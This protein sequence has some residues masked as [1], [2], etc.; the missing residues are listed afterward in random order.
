MSIYDHL[1]HANQLDNIIVVFS[2]RSGQAKNLDTITNCLG[3]KLAS[4][5][6]YADESTSCSAA[7]SDADGVYIEEFDI[8]VLK[9]NNEQSSQITSLTN[10][11]DIESVEPD[12]IM[13]ALSQLDYLSG[14]K[15]GLYSG[16]NAAITQ[17]R[18]RLTDA[19]STSEEIPHIPVNTKYENT[20]MATWGMQAINANTSYSGRGIKVAVLDTGLDLNHPD[21]S[22]R[23]LVSKSFVSNEDVQDRNGHGTHC[24]GSACGPLHTATRPRYG[25]AYD[26]DIYIGKVLSNSGSGSTSWVLDGMRWAI[27]QGCEIISMSLGSRTRV[28]QGYSPAYERVGRRA[29]EHGSIII[30]AAGND[31]GRP[32]YREP[33]SSPANCPSIMS[34]AALDEDLGI[35]TFSN[36]GK[37]PQSGREV[38]IAAP[39]VN[40]F[41]SWPLTGMYNSI[42][43]TSMAT[44]H[45]AGVAALICEKYPDLRGT[46]L[47][48]HL[49]RHAEP[50]PHSIMDVGAGIV[51]CPL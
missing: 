47:W 49:T 23:C 26:A 17:M 37:D 12:V 45:V 40:I 39:G 35:A 31:S 42:S 38:D 28:G 8:A 46:D 16:A 10:N 41:S 20:K 36:A 1:I 50:L 2:D 4:T 30:A 48:Q 44:P 9:S 15:D 21:F 51:Q 22:N 34:V 29:L 24:I 43:G 14:L 27:N 33:V 5:S 32:R 11:P 19:N 6:D 18:K 7:M 3:L 25:V 13:T